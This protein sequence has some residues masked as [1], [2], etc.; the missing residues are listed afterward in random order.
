MRQA[1]DIG[2][3]PRGRVGRVVLVAAIALGLS[4]VRCADGFREDE[5]ECE[6]AMNYLARCCA[7]F[8]KAQASCTYSS[9]G[10]CGNGVAVAPIFT[11]DESHCIQH[12]S[13]DELRS[14]GV[15]ER[16]AHLPYVP[17]SS[18]TPQPVCP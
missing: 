7:G 13:C 15:C 18:S 11:V 6:E 3:S 17:P 9:S 14:S 10:G 16:A 5:M 8:Q 12:R 1:R 4:G 2:M